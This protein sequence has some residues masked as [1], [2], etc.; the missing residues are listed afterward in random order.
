MSSH[1]FRYESTLTDASSTRNTR[2][3]FYSSRPTQTMP[4][5]LTP[6][7]TRRTKQKIIL[8]KSKANDAMPNSPTLVIKK[9][10]LWDKD[11]LSNHKQNITS[12]YCTLTN[13]YSKNKL[14]KDQTKLDSLNEL[15]RSKQNYNQLMEKGKKSNKILDD[16]YKS[17]NKEQGSI[18]SN[19]ISHTKSKFNNSLTTTK[20]QKAIQMD[21][22]IDVNTISAMHEPN[23]GNEYYRKVIKEKIKYETQLR[24]EL[25]S[26]SNDIYNKKQL[27]I[28]LENKLSEIYLEKAKLNSTFN[29]LKNKYK[30]DLLNLQDDYEKEVREAKSVIKKT[31]TFKNEQLQRVQQTSAKNYAIENKLKK[32]KEEYV[33]NIK[34]NNKQ[35]DEVVQRIRITDGEIEYYKQ[36][37]DELIKEQRGYYLGIVSNGYDSREE[38]LVW[39]VR[40][41]L[42]LGTNLEYCHFPKFLT[43][44]QDDYLLKIGKISLEET[45]LKIILKALK[46]KQVKIRLDDNIKKFN[47][48]N[49]YLLKVA[50]EEEMKNKAL[51][52][53]GKSNTNL[54]IRIKSEIDQKFNV[55]Y[56]K[57]E[58]AFKL[59]QEKREEDNKMQRLA[60]EIRQRLLGR[61]S[62]NDE[63]NIL[64]YFLENDNHKD[65]FNL[66][67]YTRNR[68][69][70]LRNQR[71][72]LRKQQIDDYKERLE[73]DKEA[74]NV[75]LKKSMQN[76][77][78]KA[79]LFGVNV[80]I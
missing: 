24:E 32:L 34:E 7:A 17:G 59:F 22:N 63:E 15:L 61:I 19:N 1:H 62:G 37:N 64:K 48:V 52:K 20:T 50:K 66:I 18:L 11:H 31:S 13:F 74:I 12:I 3:T 77:L 43:H 60:F 69:E 73:K 30:V 39:A 23:T 14:P 10:N 51:M 45:Q 26:L 4:N 46:K 28:E 6:P 80:Q 71:E 25:M 55:L 78:V 53:G 2:S 40:R 41:L 56:D 27:K 29:K 38:G 67:I 16:F 72:K 8:L 75:T 54:E 76:E 44:A 57:H 58:E 49:D 79:C 5:I 33:T 68:I 47:K 70:E 21:F 42:E 35:R 9:L 65:L 36:V